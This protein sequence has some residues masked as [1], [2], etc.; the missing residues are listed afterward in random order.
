[1]F[2][3]IWKP[4]CAHQRNLRNLNQLLK[5]FIQLDN[6]FSAADAKHLG[7]L[8][9]A[10]DTFRNVA[11]VFPSRSAHIIGQVLTID[12]I[13]NVFDGGEFDNLLRV[14]VEPRTDQLPDLV[15]NPGKLV[16]ANV[17]DGAW[18]WMKKHVIRN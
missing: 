10:G 3:N 16:D 18:R 4:F 12:D 1:M 9:D 14:L 2:L 17:R 8:L 7:H 13:G 5:I 11:K 15:E 6:I